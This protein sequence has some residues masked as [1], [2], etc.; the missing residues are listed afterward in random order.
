MTAFPDRYYYEARWTIRNLI[1]RKISLIRCL[2]AAVLAG[3]VLV[4]GAVTAG[5]LSYAIGDKVT[6]SGTA[7]ATNTMYLFVTGPGLDPNGVNPGQMKSPVVSGDPSTFVQVDVVNDNWS[8]IWNT[9]HQGFSLKEGRYTMY[10]VSQPVG[11]NSL[12]TVYGTIEISLTRS[13]EALPTMGTITITTSPPGAAMYVDSQFI[14]ITPKSFQ[15]ATG[16]HTLRIES[17]GYQTI[18][19]S[20]KVNGGETTAIEKILVPVATVINNVTVFPTTQV[21]IT[22]LPPLPAGT[23]TLP[24][25]LSA[26]I[27]VLALAGT[28][29]LQWMKHKK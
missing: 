1:M 21:T 10:A 20:L 16:T 11:K 12:P 22:T 7:Y 8:Y 18:L 25:P 6:L 9:A 13:G 4:C 5:M 23:T 14:G 3:A 24:L 26:G 19:E 17:P 2:T 15:A 28:A 27:G 29:L